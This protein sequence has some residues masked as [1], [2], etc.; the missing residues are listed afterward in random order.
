MEDKHN[1]EEE[2]GE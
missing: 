1:E 2:K